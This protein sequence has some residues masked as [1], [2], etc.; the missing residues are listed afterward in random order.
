[1]FGVSASRIDQRTTWV[2]YL[3]VILKPVGRPF[4]DVAGHFMQP[5]SICRKRPDRRSPFITVSKKILP[6]EL[7]LP[8]VAH[9]LAIRLQSVALYLPTSH[10]PRRPRTPRGR[11]DASK[12]HQASCLDLADG[13]SWRPAHRST[14]CEDCAGRQGHASCETPLL[15][16]A[17]S[18]ASPPGNPRDRRVARPA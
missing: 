17:A 1:M 5:I 2:L 18:L 15:P 6:R 10:R 9:G 7:A 13:A 12:G 14:S 8:V 3:R 16:V 4:P 11:R